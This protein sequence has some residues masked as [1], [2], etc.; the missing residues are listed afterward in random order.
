MWF[1]KYNFVSLQLIRTKYN[2]IFAAPICDD[3]GY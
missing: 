2:P 3:Q 1:T